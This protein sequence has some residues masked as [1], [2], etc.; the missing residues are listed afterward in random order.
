MALLVALWLMAM[1]YAFWWFLVR[2]IRSFYPPGQEQFVRFENAQLGKYLNSYLYSNNLITNNDQHSAVLIHFWD[3][4]CLCSRFNIQHVQRLIED[5]GP[6]GIRFIV[7]L[8][9]R[10]PDPEEFISQ[11]PELFPGAALI[12][13]S[14]LALPSKVPASPATAILDQ[15]GQLAYFGPYTLGALCLP[16]GDG[17]VET[18]LKSLLAGRQPVPGS[19]AGSGCFCAWPNKD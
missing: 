4:S 14:Q 17:L 13:A 11:A 6:D 5:F 18:V 3:P 9:D 1:C 10:I 2:D 7:I 16:S 19:I 8:N 12:R 15:H